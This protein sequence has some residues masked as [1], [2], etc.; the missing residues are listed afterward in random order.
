[1]KKIIPNKFNE[2]IRSL[3]EELSQFISTN[4]Y[5]NEQIGLNFISLQLGLSQNLLL[6]MMKCYML[7]NTKIARDFLLENI[8]VEIN[9]SHYLLF[10]E[11]SSPI[12]KLYKPEILIALQE[13]IELLIN[14]II[15]SIKTVDEGLLF[16]SVLEY[17]GSRSIPKLTSFIERFNIKDNGYIRLHSGDVDLN[18]SNELYE[19]FIQEYNHL[20]KSDIDFDHKFFNCKSLEYFY[21]YF[22]IIFNK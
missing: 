16:L 2:K 21:K 12:E 1:M 14:P 15:L 19:A 10:Q 6:W 20:D 18:H 7:C 13:K 22:Q 8:N 4:G 3:G 17:S 9:E 11:L 5:N